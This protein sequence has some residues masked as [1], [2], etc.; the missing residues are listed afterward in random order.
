MSLN[1][2][3]TDFVVKQAV[4]PSLESIWLPETNPDEYLNRVLTPGDTSLGVRDGYNS[5]PT[6]YTKEDFDFLQKTDNWFDK[7]DRADY[8]NWRNQM[9]ADEGVQNWLRE[10]AKAKPGTLSNVAQP[11]ALATL[12]G[13]KRSPYNATPHPD[14]PR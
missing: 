9:D 6:G 5:M 1:K 4:A 2:T 7:N 3:L 10:L 8:P 12:L 14:S 13:S 11:K